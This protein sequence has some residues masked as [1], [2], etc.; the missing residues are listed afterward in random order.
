[1]PSGRDL[2]VVLVHGASADASY[3]TPVIRE[4]QGRGMPVLAPPSPLRGLAGDA[5][6]LATTSTRSTGPC[7]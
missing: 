7:S 1:M 3:R 5:A 4:L 2:T 6:Y